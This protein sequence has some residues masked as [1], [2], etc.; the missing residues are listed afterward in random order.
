MKNT[1]IAYI[2]PCGY[3]YTIC[4]YTKLTKKK[5]SEF[6]IFESLIDA[7]TFAREHHIDIDIIIY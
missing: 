1:E 3:Y 4:I 2:V 7:E 5:V 6:G